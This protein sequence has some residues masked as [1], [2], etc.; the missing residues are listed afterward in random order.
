MKRNRII[1]VLLLLIILFTF[2]CCKKDEVDP[3]GNTVPEEMST[4]ENTTE[5]PSAEESTTEKGKI[6][7]ATAVVNVREEPNTDCD[8]IG[9]LSLGESI[10][11]IEHLDNGWSAVRYS[12]EK[13][14]ISTQYLSEK[15][16]SDKSDFADPLAAERIVVDP[17]EGNPYLVV[18]NAK[19]A[20]DE[21][22]KPVLTEIFDTGYYMEKGVTPYY[23]EMYT[24]AKKDGITL[25]PYSAY[26]SY[27][28][29]KNNYI[30]LTKQYMSQYNLN[31][32]DAARKAATV[33]LP[34]GTS[35]HNLGLAMDICNTRDDF[36]NTKEFKW[37]TENAHKY[38]FILRYTA[39]KQ[40]I[41]GIV[42]EPWHWRFVGVEYAEAIKDSGLCLEEY[43]GIE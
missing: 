22:Y 31:E 43:L 25:T 6:L 28:R 27:E 21:T 1:A 10:E 13:Y 5:A 38:G 39:E 18:V 20:T 23:E 7:Y 4:T 14:Y 34:P 40:D 29:Q 33:I 42:P 11:L 15:K 8:V 26:R 9:Q 3:F 37:L 30:N 17:T 35:E 24:A 12:G 41:T 16:P 32:E 2:S 36:A 19:R